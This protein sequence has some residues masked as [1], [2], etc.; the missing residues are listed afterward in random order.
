MTA[1]LAALATAEAG[2]REV[3]PAFVIHDDE[4]LQKKASICPTKLFI[5]GIS[6]HTTTKQLR[7]HFSQYGEVLDCIA[8]RGGDGR[9]RGFGYVT[10]DSPAAAQRCLCEPQLI[11]NRIVD[12]KLAVPENTPSSKIGFGKQMGFTENMPHN[13]NYSAWMGADSLEG[14][15]WWPNCPAQM[16]TGQY[17]QGLDCLQVLSQTRESP[18]LSAGAPEFVPL[19][20][21]TTPEAKT[22]MS[23]PSPVKKRVTPP[24]EKVAQKRAPLGEITNAIAN[25]FVV[26]DLLKPFKSPMNKSMGVGHLSGQNSDKS[27]SPTNLD[28]IPVETHHMGVLLDE[29][30]LEEVQPLAED[31]AKGNLLLLS[32]R[33][34][35]EKANDIHRIE[36]SDENEQVYSRSSSKSSTAEESEPSSNS[37]AL[38]S[39]GSALHYAGECKRCNFF[40]KGRCQN[41]KDCSFC[42]FPH[43]VRKPTRQEKRDRRDSKLQAQAG[44]DVQEEAASCQQMPSGGLPLL[45]CFH[46][47]SF[48]ANP[49]SYDHDNDANDETYAYSIFPGLPPVRAMK[50]PAPLALPTMETLS[51]TSPA[52]PPGLVKG[53]RSGLSSHDKTNAAIPSTLLS[54]TP[55]SSSIPLTATAPVSSALLSTTPAVTTSSVTEVK[56]K[57]VTMVTAG[58]QTDSYSCP[59]CE[60]R[61]TKGCDTFANVAQ[62]NDHADDT[63]WTRDELLRL[64]ASCSTV[65]TSAATLCRMKSI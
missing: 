50:L 21:K 10:L 33:T 38:P 35:E 40:A 17:E 43:D 6:R 19:S 7:D 64:R 2:S 48:Q 24:P 46:V 39:V 61:S 4:K 51:Q 25:V 55:S 49:Y 1:M 52:L 34:P 29:D 18:S 28:S 58:T 65:Q 13:Y 42:H 12:M 57:T 27:E 53:P 63:R 23:T 32:P 11:D 3:P 9:P 45:D 62:N 8:M 30:C 47:D 5:G 36:G 54:T 14:Q 15:S 16:L 37:D 41:G 59:Q 20:E 22:T 60:K 31:L 44:K 26:D 56:T